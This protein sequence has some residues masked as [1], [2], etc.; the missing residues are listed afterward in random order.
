M[1]N[2]GSNEKSVVSCPFCKASFKR[3]KEL[4]A[5]KPLL[6]CAYCG[7]HLTS[8]LSKDDSSQKTEFSSVYVKE[9][10]PDKSLIQG[11]IGNYLLLQSL[12]KGGMGEIFLA[13]DT[14]SGRQVALK[15]IRPDFLSTPLLKQR[16]LKEAR[17]TS[18]LIHPSIIPIYNIHIEDDLV[19]YTMPYVQGKT[20]RQLLQQAKNEEDSPVT[21][22]TS[23]TALI[24]IFLAVVQAI[25]YAHS[26]GILHR[27]IK[28]ENIIIGH[29][30]QIIILDWGLTK[31]I[32]EQ[33][34]VNIHEHQQTIITDHSPLTRVGKLVGTIA[35]MAPERAKGKPSSIQTDIY[36]L[37]VILYQMLTLTFPFKRKSINT[38]L[39]NIDHEQ[40]TPPEIR[41]PYR[42][43]PTALS[44]LVKGCLEKDPTKRIQSCDELVQRIE[45][46]LEGT[47]EWMYAQSL[48]IDQK[49]DWQL[50]ENILFS[51]YTSLLKRHESADWYRLL[52]SQ[53]AFPDN[54]QVRL[55]C[56]LH[57]GSK[58]I[59]ILLAIP[60]EKERRALTDG[61]CLWLATEKESEHNTML[62]RSSAIVL[63]APDVSLHFEKVY[64]IIVEKADR[65]FV[66]YANGK[67]ILRHISHVPV[68]GSHIG[69]LVKDGL[70]SI[71][72]FDVSIGS[73]NIMI[74]C[75]AIPDAFLAAKFYDNAH[76]LYK[77]LAHFFAGRIE[78]REALFRGGI[79]LLEMS[80]QQTDFDERSRLQNK[81][82][83]HFQ[84]LRNTPSAPLEYLGKAYVYQSTREYEEESKCF[85]IAFRR[86][87]DHPY[88]WML[89]EQLIARLHE[90][91]KSHRVAASYFIALAL[92]FL[93]ETLAHSSTKKLLQQSTTEWEWPHYFL[94]SSCSSEKKGS[95]LLAFSFWL[96]V[97]Y[98]ATEQLSS[99]FCIPVLPKEDIETAFLTLKALDCE[100]EYTKAIQKCRETLSQ[101]EIQ[102][103]ETL[104][105]LLSEP[106]HTALAI[107]ANRMQEE[108]SL[109]TRASLVLLDL[110]L[111]KDPSI[112]SKELLLLFI[113]QNPL[114]PFLA[115][116]LIEVFFT[117]HFYEEGL[118]LLHTME[119]NEEIDEKSPL[120][121]LK[122]CAI[123]QTEG[124]KKALHFFQSATDLAY[125][126]SWTIAAHVLSGKIQLRKKGWLPRAYAYE[127][128]TLERHLKLFS[129]LT[130][131]K[132]VLNSMKDLLV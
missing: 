7:A 11:S 39:A 66:V 82:L 123:A 43:I 58:G 76:L 6:F 31:L 126:P 86:Y 119:Q 53:Q 1:T 89:Y 79:A 104:F 114:H 84:K 37:G 130:D 28:P 127:K 54:V 71:D 106:E 13:Y 88:I 60:D 112:A 102:A 75:L 49:E 55:T 120:F 100:T 17:I 94:K 91:S 90:L 63:E 99:F 113:K 5:K 92:R 23:I 105:F 10:L 2:E 52:I 59:G 21:H 124:E 101:D 46:Y 24:R 40:Y 109:C 78:G 51:E 80:K 67:E 77:K 103:Y 19:Y 14:I 85:E 117:L 12:A 65:S 118:S 122:G 27:D 8:P 81:A 41:A 68:V 35:Y 72:A 42:D 132:K 32:E 107:A 121:F 34:P 29:Y 95:V 70:F 62:L 116:R 45:N 111:Q 38:F 48:H 22:R 4:N 108:Q 18:Q 115:A 56:T 20:L 15:R 110:I 131:N 25:A 97:P 64:E 9:H 129:T 69:L 73:Q 16:F 96:Q 98:I 61:Y 33:E 3:S 30:G 87:A 50:Q 36:A 125:P 44:E 74:N 93:P 128:I 26:R 47:S 83:S 57:T